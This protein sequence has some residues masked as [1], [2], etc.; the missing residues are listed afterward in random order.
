LIWPLF[1]VEG[2]DVETELRSMPGVHVRS[3]DRAV[4]AAREAFAFGIQA[5][6][7][8]PRIETSLKRDD[9]VAALARDGLA[10]RTARALK[11]ALPELGVI[12]DVALDPYTVHGHDGLWWSVAASTTI[13]P[14]RFS[15][16]W[17]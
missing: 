15:R 16:Q 4:T 17:P 1:I 8:F 13:K 10:C 6:A 7:V 14:W 11:N 3:I 12:G 9:G 2:S 5:V